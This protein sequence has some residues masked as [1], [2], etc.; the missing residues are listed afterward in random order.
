MNSSVC[1]FKP[2]IPT[3]RPGGVDAASARE[4]IAH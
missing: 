3:A 2:D 1:T 4:E